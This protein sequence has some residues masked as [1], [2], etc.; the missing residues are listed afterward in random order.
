VKITDQLPMLQITQV[1]LHFIYAALS[2]TTQ[3]QV[4]IFCLIF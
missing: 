4:D 1:S 2:L 3:S